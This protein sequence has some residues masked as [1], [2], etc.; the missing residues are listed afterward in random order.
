MPLLKEPTLEPRRDVFHVGRLLAPE[1][2]P[3]P[4]RDHKIIAGKSFGVY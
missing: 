3:L 4:R 1:A 2:G